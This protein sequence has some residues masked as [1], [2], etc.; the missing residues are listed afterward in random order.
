[1]D[2]DELEAML[3][4]QAPAQE[5]SGTNWDGRVA[6]NPRT[7]ERVVYRMN[8]QGRGRFVALNS[9]TAAPAARERVGEL[10]TRS[11]TGRRTLG[12]AREFVDLNAEARTGGV[13]ND[14]NLPEF[15]R[16]DNAQRFQAL[17]NQMVGS[18]WQPG[19]S[20]MMNTAIEQ[21]MMR[22]RYPSP[23]NKGRVNRDVYLQM[24]EDVGVQEAAV[25]DMRNWLRQ[26]P[27]L[28]GWDEH[29]AQ[30]EARLRPQIRARAV[31]DFNANLAPRGDGGRSNNTARGGQSAQRRQGGTEEWVRDPRTGRLR[32]AG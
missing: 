11:Q 27:T 9:D 29:W 25:S 16:P 26:N 17:S 18:N 10:T 12:L 1:M 13:Q 22:L 28:D 19:T 14:P 3:A 8:A 4:Q 24:A 21:N 23:T 15:I 31:R 6:V 5:Q 30:I 7:G 2:P 20:G 32:P